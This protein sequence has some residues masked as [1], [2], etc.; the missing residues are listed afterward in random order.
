ML[1]HHAALVI[2]MT[3]IVGDVDI[4]EQILACHWRA[5][6]TMFVAIAGAEPR[7]VQDQRSAR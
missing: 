4:L 3:P 6:V 2:V 5:V 1:T 7:T